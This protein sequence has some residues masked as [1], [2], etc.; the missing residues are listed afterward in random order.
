M[1][2][3]PLVTDEPVGEQCGLL[4]LVLAFLS[5]APSPHP[6][7]GFSVFATDGAE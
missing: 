2:G 5:K 1:T 3:A 6:W 7:G 4:P